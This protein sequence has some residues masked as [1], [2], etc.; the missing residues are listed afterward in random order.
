MGT[1]LRMHVQEL[2]QILGI[3]FKAGDI[4]IGYDLSIDIQIVA[5]EAFD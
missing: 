4:C 5:E 2:F 1:L 3:L